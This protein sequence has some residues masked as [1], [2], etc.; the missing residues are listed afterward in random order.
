MDAGILVPI[1]FFAAVIYIIHIITSYKLRRRLIENKMVDEN[2]HYLFQNDSGRGVALKWG[3]V[4]ISIG[5]AI[6]VSQLVPARYEEIA[7]GSAI[8]LFSGLAL[9]L[10]YFLAREKS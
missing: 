5:V 6:I 4:L 10:Y 3:M 7:L 9:I 1:S 8:F 2:T